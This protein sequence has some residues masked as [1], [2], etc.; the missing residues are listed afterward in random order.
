MTPARPLHLLTPAEVR[1]IFDEPREIP[2][3]LRDFMA[4]ISPVVDD[5]FITS[6][7]AVAVTGVGSMRRDRKI[8]HLDKM[9]S[10]VNFPRAVAREIDRVVDHVQAPR[11]Y[12]RAAGRIVPPLENLTGGMLETGPPFPTFKFTGPMSPVQRLAYDE[13][14]ESFRVRRDD[15]VH[16]VAHALLCHTLTPDT[17]RQRNA[18]D[19]ID[20]ILKHVQY[21]DLAASICGVTLHNPSTWQDDKVDR[22]QVIT[23][24][25]EARLRDDLVQQRIDDALHVSPARHVLAAIDDLVIEYCQRAVKGRSRDLRPIAFWQRALRNSPFPRT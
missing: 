12:R 7:I 3:V 20:R 2:A 17:F 18:Q 9:M 8:K 1:R 10:E 14:M 23:T 5:D 15:F 19:V 25:N 21:L 4:V 6:L 22:M 24:L 11:E 13:A 16:H